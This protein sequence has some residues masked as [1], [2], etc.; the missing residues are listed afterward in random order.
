MPYAREKDLPAAVRRE[1]PRRARSIWRN[2]FNQVLRRT[3][4]ENTAFKS[5]WGAVKNAGYE[6]DEKTG[7]YLKKRTEK[8]HRPPKSVREAVRKGWAQQRSAGES[9]GSRICSA[10]LEAGRSIGVSKLCELQT[11]FGETDAE[12]EPVSFLL[13]GG[14]PGRLWV[15]GVLKGSRKADKMNDIE[16]SA[17]DLDCSVV[18]VDK[19]R[20]LVFGYGAIC[21]VGGLPYVDSDDDTMSEDEMLDMSFEFMK[22]AA[23]HRV[24]HDGEDIGTFVFAWPMTQEVADAYHIE[25]PRTGLMVAAYPGD[26]DVLKK[27]ENGELTGFSIKGTAARRVPIE[28]EE[29]A[30]AE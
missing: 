1:L 20:G 9:P 10:E 21:T 23:N 8:C 7:K 4:R 30:Y 14:E 29:G 27:Y 24:M 13:A 25:T 11:F 3:G 5:A 16:S 28:L 18:K 26:A 19:K 22:S 17:I 6:K 12:G 15:T 2:A